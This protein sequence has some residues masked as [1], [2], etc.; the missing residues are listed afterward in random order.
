MG[1]SEETADTD[2]P[3]IYEKEGVR[4]SYPGNWKITE[5]TVNISSHHIF[6]E[7][8][9]NALFSIQIFSN[10]DA[11]PLHQF[12]EQFSELTQQKGFP[13]IS[14]R[15]FSELEESINSIN[16]YSIQETFSIKVS[17]EQ[18]PHVRR[19]YSVT[20]DEKTAYLISQA[21]TEDLTKVESGF[22]L[23]LKSLKISK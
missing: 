23:I 1:H 9:G 19:Y 5:D 8:P 13:R 21:A 7:S 16:N 22:S 3:L 14:N 17:G 6:I 11:I 2:N 20:N 18:A 10:I 15:V 4:F 12:A